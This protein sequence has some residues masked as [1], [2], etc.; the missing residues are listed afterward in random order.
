MMLLRHQVAEALHI[1]AIYRVDKAQ[2]HRSSR[3]G[4]LTQGSHRAPFWSVH[5]VSKLVGGSAGVLSILM[6]V[7]RR[8]RKEVLADGSSRHWSTSSRVS[9]T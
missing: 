6:R 8:A 4:F 3:Q 9:L 2:D 1:A 5:V 7:A